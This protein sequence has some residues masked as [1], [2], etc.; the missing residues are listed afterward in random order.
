[1][2]K[3]NQGLWF[4]IH[5]RVQN[6]PIFNDK[7]VSKGIIL[8]KDLMKNETCFH[9]HREICRHYDCDIT[10]MQYNSIMSAIPWKKKI[11]DDGQYIGVTNIDNILDTEMYS[12][13][14]CKKIYKLIIKKKYNQMPTM[15]SMYSD[16]MCKKI[17][18]LIIKKKYNQ[19]P[20]IK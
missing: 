13:G 3:K 14:M 11:K 10:L 9:K 15:K 7:M 1:M 6:K 18:K 4:N 17:Y 8:V 2:N 20:T 16:G 12:D 19:M 5:I